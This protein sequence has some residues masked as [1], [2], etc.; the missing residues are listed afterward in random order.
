[1]VEIRRLVLAASLIA[2]TCVEINAQTPFRHSGFDSRHSTYSPLPG[3]HNDPALPPR[4]TT[5]PNV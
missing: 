4:P 1:M 3:E 5:W 2:L